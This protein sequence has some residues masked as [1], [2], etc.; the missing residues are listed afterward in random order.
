MVGR[1]IFQDPYMFAKNSPWESMTKEQR[2]ALYRKHVQLF[3]D[4]WKDNERKVITLNKFCKIY[5]NGFDGAKELRER[6]MVANSTDGLLSIL[7]QEA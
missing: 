3:A 1:G 7:D 5:I 2:I 6:L 4:T